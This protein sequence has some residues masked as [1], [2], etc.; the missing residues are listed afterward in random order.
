MALSLLSENVKT[1][2]ERW[3]MEGVLNAETPF[4]VHVRKMGL[5]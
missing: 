4:L 2:V 1:K 5:S 3:R